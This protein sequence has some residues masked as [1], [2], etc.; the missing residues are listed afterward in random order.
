MLDEKLG[1]LVLRHK[2]KIHL[3][4]VP[5]HQN[6][7]TFD[8]TCDICIINA[9]FQTDK[10]LDLAQRCEFDIYKIALVHALESFDPIVADFTFGEAAGLDCFGGAGGRHLDERL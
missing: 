1:I 5:N 8:P 7:A 4:W 2:A 10:G 3:H 9:R 6:I